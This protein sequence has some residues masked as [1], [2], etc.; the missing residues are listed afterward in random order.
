MGTKFHI[1]KIKDNNDIEA[2]IEFIR[3]KL[4]LLQ[5]YEITQ[6]DFRG[7]LF[8]NESTSMWSEVITEL[9]DDDIL[10]GILNRNY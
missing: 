3:E 6:R 8:F 4:N 1:Y 5:Y 10:G 7:F 9:I 2:L